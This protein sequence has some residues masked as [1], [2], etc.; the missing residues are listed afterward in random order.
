MTDQNRRWRL[1]TRPQGMPKESDWELVASPPPSPGEGRLVARACWLSVDPYMRGRVA[2]VQSYAK[3]VEP[4]EVMQ[5][6][7]VGVVVASRHPAFREGD[8]VESMG[9]GWQD[10]AELAPQAA[11]K[12]DPT[13]GPMRHALGVLGMPGLTAYFALLDVGKPRPGD[14]VVVSSASG[15]VGQ[16]VGQIAKIAGC[17]AVAVAGSAAKLAWCRELGFDAGVDHR[18]ND[19]PAALAAACPAGIDVYFDNTG[20]PIFDAVMP[21]IAVGAR[22]VQCG[23]IATY[24]RIGEPDIGVRHHR[25]LLVKRA[26]WTGFLYTDWVHRNA[27]GLARLAG[28]IREGRMRYRE[29]VV[30]G[31]EAMPRAFLRLLTG[32]N[33]GKQLVRVA[34][35]PASFAGGDA[36]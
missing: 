36:R 7:G 6:G 33:F 31:I 12:V 3:G 18:A 20:G 21:L 29:D 2:A 25:Q 9:W 13:L 11:R 10:Y 1:K 27:E 8:V 24:N 14:T 23:V 16:V 34:P 26:S 28:W 17:R 19:M 5:G 32:E 4:G 22:I 30:D 35:E 15:A